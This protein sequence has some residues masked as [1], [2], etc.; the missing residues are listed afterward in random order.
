[1][2][3]FNPPA[4]FAA[5]NKAAIE[6][7]LSLANTTFASAERLA[8][9]NMNTARSLLED[10]VGNIRSLLAAKTPQEMLNMQAGLS[11]PA[12]EKAVAYARG[13]YEITAQ[14]QEELSVLLES[15]LAELNKSI[16]IALDLLVKTAPT[17]SELA[18]SAVKSAIAAT[19]HAFDSIN[20]AARQV[21]EIAETNMATA[22]SATIKAVTTAR[23]SA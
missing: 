19:N 21:A 17:G 8:A 2:T 23:K 13:A 6:A 5:S 3:A 15:Q 7:L 18:V 22:T 10:G 4:Q 14:S 1:M 11:Q 16:A 12:V 20:K 9:L